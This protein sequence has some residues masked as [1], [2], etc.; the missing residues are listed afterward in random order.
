MVFSFFFYTGNRCDTFFCKRNTCCL[1]CPLLHAS[2][3]QYVAKSVGI[4]IPLSTKKKITPVS[5]SEILVLILFCEGPKILL[6]DG[7][8][9]EVDPASQ[10]CTYRNLAPRVTIFYNTP[11]GQTLRIL[12]G[13]DQEVVS[14]P[15]EIMHSFP[16]PQYSSWTSRI[17]QVGTPSKHC[18]LANVPPCLPLS[19][20]TAVSYLFLAGFQLFKKKL[21][22]LQKPDHCPGKRI[23][24][25]Q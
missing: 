21:T 4:L 17:L 8:G 5:V 20:A 15:A 2:I 16:K 22:T 24:N 3:Q 18:T 10:W 9:F 12:P 13:G 23:S 6:N 14:G 7:S 25:L 19:Y 11:W 1:N